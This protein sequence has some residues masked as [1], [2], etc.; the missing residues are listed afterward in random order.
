MEYLKLKMSE[1]IPARLIFYTQVGF[2][3]LICIFT[4][5]MTIVD[6]PNMSVYM[7]IF[8]STAFA[9]MPSPATLL[10]ANKINVQRSS[11]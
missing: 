9:W 5:F 2:S 4:G 1:P 8:C 7:P 6:K 11:V 10:K 3:L